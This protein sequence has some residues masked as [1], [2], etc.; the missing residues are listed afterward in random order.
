M[1]LVA[2]PFDR[3]GDDNPNGGDD[4]GSDKDSSEEEEQPPPP[5]VRS[6]RCARCRDA[7]KM[8]RHCDCRCIR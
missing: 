1:A 6:Q 4:G 8:V 3:R 5:K 2:Q 7:K